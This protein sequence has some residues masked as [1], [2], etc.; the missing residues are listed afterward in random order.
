MTR[1]KFIS[2]VYIQSTNRN[3]AHNS[4]AIQR[5]K[6]S[7]LLESEIQYSIIMKINYKYVIVILKINQIISIQHNTNLSSVLFAAKAIRRQLNIHKYISFPEIS[8]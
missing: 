2:S 3:E 7:I 5:E 6:L 1:L 8:K 4:H